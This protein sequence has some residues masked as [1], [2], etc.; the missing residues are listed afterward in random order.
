[1]DFD[2]QITI[3][4]QNLRYIK[5]IS[6]YTTPDPN[7]S[8]FFAK[9]YEV[10]EEVSTDSVTINIR[11]SITQDGINGTILINNAV[12]LVNNTFI[13]DNDLLFTG[14]GEYITLEIVSFSTGAMQVTLDEI[15]SILEV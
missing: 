7:P 1:M 5:I 3:L 4:H 10:T 2:D 13:F 6:N 15:T 9:L 8:P 12:I 14:L 11:S